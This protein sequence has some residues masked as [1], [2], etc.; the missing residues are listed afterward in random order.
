MAVTAVGLRGGLGG[1]GLCRHKISGKG[2]GERILDG[3]G[4]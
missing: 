4:D 3:L 1:I 2:S